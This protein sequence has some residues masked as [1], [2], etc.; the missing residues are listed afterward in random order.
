[1]RRY[2]NDE[3]LPDFATKSTS[4]AMKKTFAASPTQQSTTKKTHQL[5]VNTSRMTSCWNAPEKVATDCVSEDRI[6]SK[7][8]A[9]ASGSDLNFSSDDNGPQG[10]ISDAFSISGQ[11]KNDESMISVT[12]IQTIQTLE[13]ILPSSAIR[14]TSRFDQFFGELVTDSIAC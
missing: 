7:H 1:M 10:V 6:G 3:I 13:T 2:N 4:Q 5:V 9:S 8:T 14:K 12:D 11:S